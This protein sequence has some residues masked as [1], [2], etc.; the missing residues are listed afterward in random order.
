MAWRITYVRRVGT[1]NQPY[2]KK[3]MLDNSLFGPNGWGISFICFTWWNSCK[4]HAKSVIKLKFWNLLTMHFNGFYNWLF[5]GGNFN[6]R[7]HPTT[8]QGQ[9]CTRFMRMFLKWPWTLSRLGPCFE[10]N[11]SIEGLSVVLHA[12][13]LSS[14]NLNIY[15]YESLVL[16]GRTP[17]NTWPN[18]QNLL[19]RKICH[20]SETCRTRP[21]L[22]QFVST[23][24]KFDQKPKIFNIKFSFLRT[25]L[26]YI[27]SW[28]SNMVQ[29]GTEENHKYQI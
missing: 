18:N 20:D 26:Q 16:K 29:N 13:W 17:W 11:Y 27:R 15:F 12:I 28:I 24:L 22:K 23:A 4:F 2:S 1:R 19:R 21:Y 7:L 25:P 9:Y 10:K 3:A 8:S 5:L 6:C 14:F